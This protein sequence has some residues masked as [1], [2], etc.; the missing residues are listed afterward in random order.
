MSATMVIAGREVREKSRV[1]LLA[2]AVMVTTF[3]A[4]LLPT[5]AGH[6]AEVIAVLGGFNALA[7]GFGVAVA[8]GAS[9][10]AGDLA[11]RR[12]SFYFARPVSAAAIWFGKAGASI[13]VCVGAFLI[14]A[15]PAWL[16]SPKAWS[17]RWLGNTLLL[18]IAVGGIVVL[19]LISHFL[20]TFIRSRSAVLAIDLVM[21]VL[22]TGAALLIVRPLVSG[23][24]MTVAGWLLG[25]LGLALLLIAFIAPV[26]QLE[27]GRADI[28]RSH[29]ALSRSFWPSVSVV[30]LV[31]AVFVFWFVRVSPASLENV[32]NVM[33][34]SRGESVF[35]GG[36]SRGGQYHA[37]FLVDGATGGY[38]RQ[39]TPGWWG[40]RFSRD[41]RVA[42]WK[43]P[44][45]FNLFMWGRNDFELHVRPLAGQSVANTATG[46]RGNF[47]WMALT[48]D[49]ARIALVTHT[50]LT[51]HDTA[52][53]K[54]L[55]SANLPEAVDS[56]SAVFFVSRDVVRIVSNESRRSV[57]TVPL[58][59]HE[60]DVER[61]NMQRT[62]ERM[63]PSSLHAV[64]VSED[65]SRMFVRGS[66]SILDGRTGA[67]LAEPDVQPMS[68]FGSAMLHDGRLAVIA[69]EA[70]T[71][72]LRVFDQAGK[73]LRAI[74]LPRGFESVSVTAETESGKVLV[75]GRP[76]PPVQAGGMMIV[77]D[78]DSGT[79]VRTMPGLAGPFGSWGA[80]PRLTRYAEGQ[81]LVAQDAN[82]K[83]MLW[84]PATGERKA[85]PLG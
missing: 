36:T 24:A 19:F 33:Q 62:G 37:A 75:Y 56:I 83:L 21:F 64:S 13:A 67:L 50:T 73:P 17:A 48:D 58:R 5:S 2:A 16:V 51:V 52:T 31:A 4:A 8:L 76:A 82:R 30:V 1:L 6:R 28:Q 35:L 49:G 85:L 34:P 81:W 10:I 59:I 43:Q 66:V 53:M 57:E 29:A 20:S 71:L 9:V 26:W 84:N 42:A 74:A 15:V 11:Q 46:I 63:I 77:V 68:R 47:Q 65:G 69:R 44:V 40:L 25:G 55:A 45:G 54:L 23:G 79:I 27:N 72:A 18:A 61:R 32:W 41:G 38:E 80:D 78:P 39:N 60:F 7:V 3:L 14:I 70:D 12:M 22:T